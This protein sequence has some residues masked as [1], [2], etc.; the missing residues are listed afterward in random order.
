M[1]T[2][3]HHF[4]V[5]RPALLILVRK[6]KIENYIVSRLGNFEQMTIEKQIQGKKPFAA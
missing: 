1:K 4:I 6:K 5:S 2:Y 3:W